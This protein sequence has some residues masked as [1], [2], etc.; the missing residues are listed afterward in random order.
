MRESDWSSDVCSS[1]LAWFG[2]C[3]FSIPFLVGIIQLGFHY[4][5]GSSSLLPAWFPWYE[6]LHLYTNPIMLVF[7]LVG[8]FAGV[9]TP[10]IFGRKETDP[11]IKQLK[12]AIQTRANK[13]ILKKVFLTLWIIGSFI[14]QILV[15]SYFFN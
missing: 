13:L 9:F 4:I 8:I 5:F 3:I 10:R 2:L 11:V 15:L 14:F 6:M 1:D 7:H 12:T